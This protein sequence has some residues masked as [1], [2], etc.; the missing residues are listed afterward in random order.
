MSAALQLDS[1]KIGHPIQ[2]PENTTTIYANLTARSG[3]RANI[4]NSK[5]VYFVGLQHFI[6][7]YLQNEWN[8]TFF[9]KP[10]SMV[11]K[12][13]QRFASANLGYTVDVSHIEAL[14]TLGYLPIV[15]KALPEGSFVPYNVPMLTIRNTDPNFAW[16][17]NMIETVLSSELWQPIT[18]ATTYMSY[19]TLFHDYAK[20]TGSPLDFV[21]RQGHDFSFRGMAGRKAAASSGFASIA[22]GSI[23]TDCIPALLLAE[24]YY[25]ANVEN[26]I[27]GESINGTEHSVMCVNGQEMEFDTIK[28]IITE[29]YP[30]G[31]VAIVVDGYDFWKVVTEYLPILKPTILARKG[32]VVIRP[33]CYS[34][35]TMTFT[36]NGWK[37][38]KDLSSEDLVAQVED[39]GTYSFVYPTD[40][41][42]Q[43]YEGEMYNFLDYHG[44]MDLLVT[45]NHRM[46]YKKADEWNVEF[47]EDIKQNNYK[48]PFI[49]SAK[50]KNKNKTLSFIERLNIAFQAD[51]S[52]CTD[53]KTSVRF[54]FS[55][56]RKIDRLEKLLNDNN[57]KYIIYD[58]KDG[59]KEFNIK[60]DASLL[61]KDFSWVDV[62]NLC[63][64]WCS[65]FIEEL[66]HW[67]SHIRNKNKIKF[68]STNLDVIN[69]VELISLSAG[70]GC[71]ISEYVDNRK[72]IFSNLHT[73]NILIDNKL[74]GQSV[75]KTILKYNGTI[76]CVTV[77]SGRLLVKR[78]RCTMVCG[79]SGDP[80]KIMTGDDDYPKGS[81]EYNGL[82]ETLWGIF[83]GTTTK[84]GFKVLDSHIGAIYG[85]SITYD[86]ADRILNNLYNKQFA[87]CNV[88]LGIGSYTYQ[89][90]TRDTHGIAMKTTFAIV[91]DEHKVVSKSPKTDSG[92]KTSAKGLLMVSKE[93]GEYKLWQNVTPKQENHG[94][95][96]PVF[97]NGVLTKFQS[98]SDIRNL[99][100]L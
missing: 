81:A 60:I 71:L 75:K 1:Y 94:C 53:M 57:I 45:P 40:R 96:E 86:R 92:M 36:P 74:G 79:N 38:F 61:H 68:D 49:R 5:G 31:N 76:H 90:V 30:E 50:A 33:D 3:E 67:D 97:K 18:S 85:D 59:R 25:D 23:G 2:Y 65:E 20:R 44:K 56:Q 15:I 16:V 73:A 84:L 63:S 4:P 70:Y 26:E 69:I 98:L 11:V 52:Y 12:D 64:N 41:V 39:D 19:K 42:K 13:F 95:L 78:N 58:L 43:H 66:S 27:V 87:S 77:P 48:K 29:V 54:A 9:S 7:D 32:T 88:V 82:I 83:G 37:Y 10:K 8:N 89:Y 14:H 17:V 22:C 24:K 93:N 46:I 100:Q 21:N 99:T 34:D 6:I 62:S 80:V 91:D 28:R 51:G 55:K 35:D 47:A 72:E